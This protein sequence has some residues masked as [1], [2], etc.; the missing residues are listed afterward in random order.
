MSK[1]SYGSVITSRTFT[2]GGARRRPRHLCLKSGFLMG[3]HKPWNRYG[4][5]DKPIMYQDATFPKSSA[6]RI[7]PRRR[8]WSDTLAPLWKARESQ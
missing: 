7:S 4:L 1:K 3:D 5:G 8:C 2:V 6:V